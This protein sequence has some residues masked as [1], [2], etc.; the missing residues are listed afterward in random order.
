MLNQIKKIF[1]EDK[2]KCLELTFLSLF[3]I[4][5]PSFEAPKNLFLIAFIFISLYR[6]NFTNLINHKWDYRDFTFALLIFSALLSALFPGIASGNEWKGFRGITLW[7]G[8]GW[9]ISYVNY[10]NEEKVFLF[11]LAILSTIPPLLFGF[12]QYFFGIKPFLE[13]HSVGHVNHSAIYLVIIFGSLFGL[14][15]FKI[16]KNN[17][18]NIFLLSLSAFLFLSLVIGQSRGAFIASLF[19]FLFF[20]LFLKNP[21]IKFLLLLFMGLLITSL[22]IF[23][24][25]IVKKQIANQEQGIILAN[26]EKAWNTAIEIS[27]MYPIFGIGN[28]NWSL[29]KWEEIKNSVESRGLFFDQNRYANFSHPHNIY[30]SSLADRGFIGLFVFINF[31]F[32]WLLEVKKLY[33]KKSVNTIFIFGSVSSWI[34]LFLIWIVN[35]TFHHE[36]ALLS[37][38]FL[39]LHLSLL[40]RKNKLSS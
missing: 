31:M 24:S 25:E 21:K 14:S 20:I 34:S 35:T 28:G 18:L 19:I 8:F 13:L 5:L 38:F 10:K 22:F 23:Q 26:R 39:G 30:F 11:Y 3:L 17:N 29:I 33:K 32:F 37:L 16:N 27:R 15:I 40:K 12:Y 36:N 1:F 9:L 6:K 7:V 2:L 4:F